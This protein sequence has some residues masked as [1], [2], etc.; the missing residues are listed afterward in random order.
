MMNIEIFHG[1]SGIKKATGTIVIIDVFRAS[2]TILA[3]LYT[4][5]KQIIPIET[6]EEARFLKHKHPTWILIGERNGKKIIG[7][8]YGNSPAK[9]N[10]LQLIDKTVI[11]STSSGTKGIVNVKNAKECL[12][13][14]FPNISTILTYLKMKRPRYISLIP[15]GLN[16]H[17][18][19]IEDTKCA[20]FIC[21]SLENQS[22]NYDDFIQ[23]IFQSQ[24]IQRLRRLGQRKDIMY[25]LQRDIFPI[26]PIYEQDKNIIRIK[27]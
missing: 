22:V 15:M 27:K 2:S 14:S 3:C 16:A 9:I 26:L 19:A 25:C 11:L 23:P 18:P 6:V 24:G 17:K 8:D 7:F 1:I 13:A 21:K 10:S 20:E 5:V 12:I 4:G